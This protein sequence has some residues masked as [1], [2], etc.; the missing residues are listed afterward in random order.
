MTTKAGNPFHYF[1]TGI[2]KRTAPSLKTTWSLQYPVGVARKGWMKEEIT[3]AQA[4][5]T[6][7][8][9]KSQDR[10]NLEAPALI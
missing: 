2:E 9:L 1:T 5:F 10:L 6:L 8:K 3:S 4:N 7:E